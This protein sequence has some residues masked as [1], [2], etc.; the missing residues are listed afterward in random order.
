M[1]CSRAD[2]ATSEPRRP[3]G[4]RVIDVLKVAFAE[5]ELNQEEYA[6]QVGETLSART[7]GDLAVLTEDLPAG[8][9]A[10]MAP[11]LPVHSRR[12]STVR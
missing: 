12:P 9:L 11:Q 10:S 2:T 6:E 7:Y 4:E 8:Q 1:E 5:G 3:T